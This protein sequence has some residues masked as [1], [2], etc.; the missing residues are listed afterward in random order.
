MHFKTLLLSLLL[1]S[2]TATAQ[3][4]SRAG[5]RVNVQN[6]HTDI[7]APFFICEKFSLAP[8]VGVSYA[9]NNTDI[10]AGF[11]PR[12]YFK[13]PKPFAPYI[14][15]TVAAITGNGVT[16]FLGGLSF[17][18]EYFFNEHFSV[19]AEAQGNVVRSDKKSMRFNNPGETTFNTGSA[20]SATV[21]F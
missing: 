3:T 14:G 15:A 18:G 20:V 2:L 7:Q 21:Y 10:L 13:A 5:I 12:F 1:G 4:G 6:T 17:G 9:N 8:V 11:A 16:D 19:A